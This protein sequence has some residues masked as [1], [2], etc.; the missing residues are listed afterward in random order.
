M[1]LQDLSPGEI[2]LLVIG[3]ILAASSFVNQVGAAAERISKAR[4]AAQAPTD[5]LST[6]VSNLEK[7]RTEVDGKLGR[8]YAELRKIH[9]GNHAI[10]QALLALLDHGIDGNNISQMQDA[11]KE[12]QDHLITQ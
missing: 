9:L 2:V 1:T 3:I 5:E 8:D 12:L 7:W 10:F 11:K 6:R 4:K